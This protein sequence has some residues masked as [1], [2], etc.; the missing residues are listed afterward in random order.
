MSEDNPYKEAMRYIEN[1]KN[2]LNTA[3]KEGRYYND[4][5]YVKIACGT[6]YSGILLA[7]DYLFD[8]KNVPKKKR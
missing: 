6:A 2:F 7:L 1:A 8:V 5:K 4:I 3:G